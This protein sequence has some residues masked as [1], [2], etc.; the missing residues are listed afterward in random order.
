MNAYGPFTYPDQTMSEEKVALLV[1]QMLATLWSLTDKE[2]HRI[3]LSAA[4]QQEVCRAI[5][6]AIENMRNDSARALAS[7]RIPT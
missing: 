3:W 1:E 7:E 6:Q 5:I 4:D 2:G